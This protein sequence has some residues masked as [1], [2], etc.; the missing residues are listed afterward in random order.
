MTSGVQRLRRARRV[1]PA[2]PTEE[3][4]AAGIY[5]IIVGA[6]VMAAAHAPTTRALVVA[7]LV[8]LAIY[9]LA[10]RYARLIAERIHE[11]HRPGWRDVRRQLTMGWEIVTA[12]LL[13]LVVLLVVGAFG[14]KLYVAVLA[15]LVCST[16]LLCVAGW[17]MGRDGKL[18]GRERVVAAGAAGMFGV[19]MILLKAL[20]H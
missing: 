20:L 8:T 5:G 3:S 14:A 12:S 9:W 7:V 15:G 19:V 18:T 13:P 11:H 2:R 1:H 6:A 10:E 17:E 16:L 4:T